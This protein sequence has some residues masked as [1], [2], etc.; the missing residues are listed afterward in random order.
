M[1]AQFT[2]A[3]HTIKFYGMWWDCG[4]WS[5]DGRICTSYDIVFWNVPQNCTL[6]LYFLRSWWIKLHHSFR[7]NL[8]IVYWFSPVNNS[9]GGERS[10]P[11]NYLTSKHNKMAHWAPTS[12]N[13]TN[14]AKLRMAFFLAFWKLK[15]HSKGLNMYQ[16]G[17]FWHSFLFLYYQ[18]F[19]VFYFACFCCLLSFIYSFFWLLFMFFLL[20][21]CFL[22]FLF[23]LCFSLV[24]FLLIYFFE[25]FYFSIWFLFLLIVKFFIC[26][27]F[28]ICVF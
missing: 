19:V 28:S 2:V 8:P 16:C 5:W 24:F 14:W 1:L 6:S 26:V 23:F 21:I 22:S 25:V 27:L 15:I 13:E 11:Q 7:L 9:W 20:C 12:L 18:I 10:L 3:Q 17:W 4:K